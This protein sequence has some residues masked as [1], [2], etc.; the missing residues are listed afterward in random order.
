MHVLIY[1]PVLNDEK[2]ISRAVKSVMNQTH[3]DWEMVISDNNSTDGTY[4]AIQPFLSDSRIIYKKLEKTVTANINFLLVEQYLLG[5]DKYTN[6]CYLASDDYWENEF[7]LENLLQ[8][9]KSKH[10]VKIVVPEFVPLNGVSLD[11]P[12]KFDLVSNFYMLRLLYLFQN[13]NSVNLIYG[14]YEK[15]FFLLM[16]TDRFSRF[17]E[18]NFADWWWAYN[19]IKNSKIFL[20][21]GTFYIK[22]T[23]K[24]RIFKKISKIENFIMIISFPFI[25]FS[26]KIKNFRLKRGLD[27]IL[28]FIY[29]SVFTL[30]S[31]FGIALRNAERFFQRTK[32]CKS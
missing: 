17:N 16:L 28:I 27:F 1:I 15:K 23:N 3:T 18:K 25:F 14:L 29:A 10:K 9:F 24:K 20:C 32:F 31:L 11:M 12:I 22:D 4:L 19:V 6:V 30:N 8:V 13:W 21:R 5:N 7:Y 26:G 2:R